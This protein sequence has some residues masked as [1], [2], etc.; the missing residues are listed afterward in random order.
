M[1]QRRERY[2]APITDQPNRR[3]RQTLAIYEMSRFPSLLSHSCQIQ[4]MHFAMNFKRFRPWKSFSLACCRQ[5]A[6]FCFF[7]FHLALSLSSFC[8]TLAVNRSP[9]DGDAGAG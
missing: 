7:L 8:S 6:N 4:I 5:L 3:S 9:I 1:L 2:E